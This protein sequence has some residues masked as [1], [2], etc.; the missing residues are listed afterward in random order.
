MW[1][2]ILVPFVALLSLLAW[3]MSSPVSSS[4]DDNYHLASIWCGLGDRADLCEP[5]LGDTEVKLVPKAAYEATCFAYNAG[6]SA[7]CLSPLYGES[8]KEL[9]PTKDTNASGGYPPVFYAVMSVFAT[10]DVWASTAMMRAFNS[11]LFVG[12]VGLLWFAL[13]LRRRGTL[14]WSFTVSVVPLGLFIIPSTNPSSWALLSAGTLWLALLGWTE[15]TGRRRFLLGALA[16]LATVIGAGA[17][18]DSAIFA[19]MSVFL[20][21]ILA[22]RFTKITLLHLIFPVALIVIATMFFFSGSQSLVASSGITNTTEVA[23]ESTLT[24]TIANILMAPSLWLGVFGSWG[25]G[26]LDTVTPAIV[27]VAAFGTFAAVLFLGLAQGL[28]TRTF[29][30]RKA[31]AVFLVFAALWTLP[32]Y[33]LVKT[34]AYVGAYVQPRYILPLIILLAGILLVRE[35][36]NGPIFSALQSLTVV[37]ALSFANSIALFWNI[38]RYVTGTD[39]TGWNLN[40]EAEWWWSTLPGPMVVWLVGSVAFAALLV[41]LSPSLLSRSWPSVVP[42]NFESITTN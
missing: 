26:W 15:T 33:V 17:R 16:L 34:G 3:G 6:Q 39:V 13:P 40:T 4:P 22:F 28:V 14:V 5:S 32:V 23:S 9:V 36:G 19:V 42:R 29:A 38:R 2:K 30:W 25:L 41:L 37:G 7:A 21:G 31:I 1:K 35:T 10:T 8:G 24:L 18:T 27:S 12:F 11:L 20:V